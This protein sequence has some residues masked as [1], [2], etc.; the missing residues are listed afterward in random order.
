MAQIFHVAFFLPFN[1]P[2]PILPRTNVHSIMSIVEVEIFHVE[3]R[4]FGFFHGVSRNFCAYKIRWRV[5]HGKM[6]IQSL[7]ATG[8]LT[9][10]RL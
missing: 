6:L 4:D 9:I 3:Y 7:Q 1:R 2:D 8:E 10:L 5:I